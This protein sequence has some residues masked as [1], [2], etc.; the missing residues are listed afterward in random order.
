MQNKDRY[1]LKK[2]LFNLPGGLEKISVVLFIIDIFFRAGNI[3]LVTKEEIELTGIWL[4]AI[5][6]ILARVW[7]YSNSYHWFRPIRS[8][9]M[10]VY[11]L[12]LIVG[13]ILLFI[14]LSQRIF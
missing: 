9:L 6:F 3:G 7:Q 12:L 1:P 10:L 4:C 11:S 5:G 13:S 14:S 8:V 2:V